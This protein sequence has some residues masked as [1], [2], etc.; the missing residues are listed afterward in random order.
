MFQE[1]NVASVFSSVTKGRKGGIVVDP[2]WLSRAGS[3]GG[4]VDD[5]L[6]EFVPIMRS[7]TS[8]NSAPKRFASIHRQLV[9]AIRER[10]SG[11]LGDVRF[12]NLMVETYDCRYRKMGWHTDQSLDLQ[13][14]SFIALFSCYNNP[15][16]KCLRT[17]NI[18]DKIS[19][20]EKAITLAHNSLVVFD[21][22]LNSRHVHQIILAPEVPCDTEDDTNT[23]WTGVTLRL[24]KTFLENGTPRALDGTV[25]HLAT[26]QERGQLLVYKGLE[27][28]TADFVYPAGID[29]TL[30][31]GDFMKVI[32]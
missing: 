13:D 31:P 8:Y 10:L 14:G 26:A 17:L 24:S 11:S 16:T 9:G 29:Y 23:L 15:E 19:G 32:D 1:L 6:R 20:D 25:F 22:R 30:D 18:R 5:D 4:D 7:T 2:I 12:N 28:K 3:G 21:T 27:N